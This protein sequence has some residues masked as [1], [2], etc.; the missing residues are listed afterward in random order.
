MNMMNSFPAVPFED[1]NN[2]CTR[3]KFDDLERDDVTEEKCESAILEKKGYSDDG[4]GDIEDYSHESND[5]DI[6][7]DTNSNMEL[8][9]KAQN[10]MSEKSICLR[11]ENDNNY[12]HITYVLKCMEDDLD[13]KN[14]EDFDKEDDISYEV[15]HIVCVAIKKLS[16]YV[17]FSTSY[18]L[19]CHSHRQ[20]PP[21]RPFR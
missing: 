11:S 16:P 20:I 9:G 3:N 7:H 13:K 15:N 10:G 8:Y 17:P 21:F 6:S 1:D 5:N 12:R 18:F 14:N 2:G 4:N 19:Y